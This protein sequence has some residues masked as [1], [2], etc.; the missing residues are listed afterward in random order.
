[1]Y[2]SNVRPPDPPEPRVPVLVKYKP[3]WMPMFRLT[4]LALFVPMCLFSL[5]FN[6][7]LFHP[8]RLFSWIVWGDQNRLVHYIEFDELGMLPSD[9]QIY[10][11]GGRKSFCRRPMLVAG[12]KD[13]LNFGEGNVSN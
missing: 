10:P 11:G 1:M 7:V 5:L 4:K 13:F 3:V 6:Y 2:R 12:T 8:V 9:A